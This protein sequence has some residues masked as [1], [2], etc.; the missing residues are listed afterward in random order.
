MRDPDEAVRLAKACCERTRYRQPTLLDTLAVAY[1]ATG[2]YDL[3][4]KYTNQAIEI[5]EESNIPPA[6]VA[7]MRTR[8]EQFERKA[9]GK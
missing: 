2:R 7:E 8:L 6:K 9:A 3:A 4:I 1:G 5:A